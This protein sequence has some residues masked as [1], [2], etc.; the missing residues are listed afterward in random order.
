MKLSAYAR[1]VG[2][3]YRTAFR[4]FKGGKIQGRQMDTGRILITEL[5]EKTSTPQHPLIVAIY[6]R[7]SAAENKDNPSTGSGQVWKVRRNARPTTAPPKA[8]PSHK[9]S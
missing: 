6:A 4:R 2:V 5:V 7:V 1:K 3:S 8:T 9:S